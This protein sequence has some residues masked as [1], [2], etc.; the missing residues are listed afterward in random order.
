[1]KKFT[2]FLFLILVACCF[3]FTGCS[4]AT[5]TMPQN[6]NNVNSNGGFVVEVGNYLYYANAYKSYSKLT[7]DYENNGEEV[8]QYS[9]KRVEQEDNAQK[10]LVLDEE[11]KVKFENVLNKIAGYETSNMFVVNEYLYFTSPNIHKND[12]KDPDKYGKFEFELSTLFRIKLDGSGFS[13]LYTTE[14]SSA[15][16]YLTGGENKKLLVFDDSKIMQLDCYNNSSKFKELVKDVESTVFPYD[17]QLE[18]ANIYFT[19][20][21]DEEDTFTGNILNVLNIS[22]A[23]TTEVAGYSNNGETI[24]LVAFDGQRLF[25]TRT[26][27]AIQALYSNDFANGLSSQ[28]LHKYEITNIKADSTIRVINNVDGY[29]IKC[30]VFEHNNNIYKQDL[31]ATNDTASIALTTE[32]DAKI[33]FVD[34]TY[35][36]Y[37]TANGIFRVSVLTNTTQQVSD[38]KTLNKDYLDFDGRYVYFYASI[39]GAESDTQYLYRADTNACNNNSIKTECIAEL[40]EKDIIEE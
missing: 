5:V 2:S 3:M 28:I 8:A 1:M 16:F 29:D 17:Q 7:Q 11:E 12:S 19:T 31:S 33:V 15:K 6:Y 22:N 20:A 26:G 4:N 35:V 9:L 37:T 38:I 14:T 39:E 34:K 30:F 36:Y 32:T 40:L 13:E 21:R 10:S 27:L 23:E 25:Y 18:I 24:T